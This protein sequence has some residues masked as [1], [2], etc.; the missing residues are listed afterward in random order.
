MKIMTT[1]T[2]TIWT[3][4]VHI[5]LNGVIFDKFHI[6]LFHLLNTFYMSGF[7][8]GISL[9]NYASSYCKI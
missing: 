3:L 4:Y 6:L 5:V 7:F 2:A 9:I 8:P 1:K